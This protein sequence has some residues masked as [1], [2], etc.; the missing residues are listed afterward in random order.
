[1]FSFIKQYAQTIV[2]IDIYPKVSLIIFLLFFVVLLI[3]VMRADKKYIEEL[4]EIPL[5]KK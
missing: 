1:M 3:T 4:S 2:G 5:D